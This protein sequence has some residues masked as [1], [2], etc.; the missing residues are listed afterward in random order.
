MQTFWFWT[1]QLP[2]WMLFTYLLGAQCTAAVNYDFG[3]RWGT[4]EPEEKVS[5]VGVAFWKGFAFADLVFYTPVLGLGLLGHAFGAGW[6]VPV[7]GAA[8]G[9]TIY[10]P[11]VSLRAVN[12]ARG[13]P[14]WALPKEKQYWVLLP[15]IAGW[16][17]IALALTV[18][19][20]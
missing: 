6:A 1:I 20:A 10:W 12:A 5:A 7:L 11:V 2:G 19:S 17:V 13:A 15:V 14:G 8:L 16:G 9:V 4:Q 18:A 3:V